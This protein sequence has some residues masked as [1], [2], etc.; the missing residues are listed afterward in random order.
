M[1]RWTW[2]N[3]VFHGAI[4]EGTGSRVIADAIARNNHLPFA[5]ADS[6]VIDRQAIGREYE[7]LRL[8]QVQHRLIVDALQ[9]RESARAEMLMREHAYIGFRYAIVCWKP[10]T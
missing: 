2:L 5:S 4:V 6:I 8:A 3:Q 10:P 9:R 7:K 1:A